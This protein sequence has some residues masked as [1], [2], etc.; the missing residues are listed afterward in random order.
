[1]VSS[2]QI[3]EEL[4]DQLIGRI[5]LEDFEAWLVSSSWDMPAY[6]W[7]EA[8]ELV[9][10]I[11]LRLAEFSLGQ[12]SERQLRDELL[13]FVRDSV[14]VSDFSPLAYP[15]LMSRAFQTFSSARPSELQW[16]PPRSRPADIRFARAPV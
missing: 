8:K 1:M 12:I 2:A 7:N 15:G 10:E 13:K 6:G 14:M 9:A 16:H 5:S 11:Q 4:I 3:R